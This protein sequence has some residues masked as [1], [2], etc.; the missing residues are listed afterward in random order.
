LGNLKEAWGVFIFLQNRNRNRNRS[1]PSQLSAILHFQQASSRFE[2]GY[3]S[4]RKATQA[5]GENTFASLSGKASSLR[6][7]ATPRPFARPVA[8]R[9][10]SGF[11]V[12]NPAIGLKSDNLPV[13]RFQARPPGCPDK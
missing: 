5:H 13:L 2:Q 8:I 1:L 6:P 3:A 4:L 12:V 11:L 10:G 7:D 9:S